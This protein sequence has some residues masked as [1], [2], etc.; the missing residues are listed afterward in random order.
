[1][2][3]VQP[4]NV[5]QPVKL[6]LEQFD[7]LD[8]SGA[9]DG[10]AKTELIEGAI[11]AM[12]GQFRP[13]AFAKTELV[14]RLHQ[15][16]KELGSPLYPIVEATVGMPP[17]SAPEPDISL[18][19]APIGKGYVPSESVALA[20]EVTDATADFDLGLKA[21]LYAKHA[22][23]EYWVVEIPAATIHQCWS[24]SEQ[25]Y[26]EGRSVPIGGSVESLTIAGLAVE[27]DGLI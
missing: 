25:G 20:I 1:M 17:L 16:L 3:V 15:V 13:H 12:Q 26:A 24:P 23:P 14:I 4:I 10:Y 21:A 6:T 2:T 7:L 19:S 27:T 18:T 8:R 22:I 9:F 5:P 11:Y